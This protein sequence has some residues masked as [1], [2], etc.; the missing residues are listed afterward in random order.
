M[1]TS[2]CSSPPC[3]S[4]STWSLPCCSLSTAA[5]CP[6]K[7]GI[8]VLQQVEHVE[9][10]QAR[11]VL[12]RLLVGRQVGAFEYDRVDARMA[13]Q[14]ITGGS[15]DLALDLLAIERRGV[16]D[17]GFCKRAAFGQATEG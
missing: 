12:D 5:C 8:E 14:Q 3:S 11:G 17:E 4:R 13:R 1:P 15:H 16:A 7:P 9:H 10:G 6:R 2:S